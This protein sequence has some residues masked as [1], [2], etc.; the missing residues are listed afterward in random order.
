MANSMRTS[1]TDSASS[2]ATNGDLLVASPTNGRSDDTLTYTPLKSNDFEAQTLIDLFRTMLLSRRLDEKMVT[3][4]KQ[5]F[6]HFHIGAAGHEAAQAAIGHYLRSGDDWFCMYYQDQCQAL[7]Q[8][9][10]SRDILLAHMAKADDPSSGGRQMPEHFTSIEKNILPSSSSVGS[11]FLPAL[12]TAMTLQ[13]EESD[14]ITYVSCGDGATSQ[15]DFHEALNWAALVQAPMLFVVQDNGYA[16]SVP[17]DQQTAGGSAYKFG[18]GYEGLTRIHVDGTD[19]FQ[20]AG[21]AKK[22]IEHIRTRKGPVLLV[23][24]VVRLMPHSSSDNHTKYRPSEE[25]S[26]DLQRDP[27]T[28][29]E[30]AL[31]EAGVLTEASAEA[32]KQEVHQQVDADAEWC[33]QQPDP[34]P[35]TAQPYFLR[36]RSRA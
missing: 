4:L 2:E 20:V 18:A 16:I 14:R 8:G 13:R 35:E 21:A 24:D 26:A 34:A 23:T 10:T 27:I 25:L 30:M 7:M 36:G 17:K 31:I 12:G 33:K 15:G 19:F 28:R 29:F 32:M 3:L 11:Q 22:A 5:G 6:G 9:M 1:E